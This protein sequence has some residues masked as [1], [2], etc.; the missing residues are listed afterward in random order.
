MADADR[1]PALPYSD[2]QLAVLRGRAKAALRKRYRQLRASLPDDVRATRSAQIAARVTALD[3]WTAARTVALFASMHDEVQTAP[4]VEAARAKGC[5]VCLPVVVDGEAALTFR[6]AYRGDE[7]MP[8]AAGVWGIEEPTAD[9]PVV[10]LAEIDLV[11]IPALA[12][13]P[14]GHRIGYGRGYYD[15][16]LPR[17]TKAARVAVAFEFQLI[18]EVPSEP[19][20]AAASWIVTD[21][22]TLRAEPDPRDAPETR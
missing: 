1:R 2:D 4:L 17:M 13:D 20:D 5:T 15:H 22:R 7:E 12:V 19:H 9:A 6:V 10:D 16:T 8:R 3:A 14:A 18:A 21:T 11:V